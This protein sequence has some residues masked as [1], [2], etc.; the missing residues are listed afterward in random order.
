MKTRLSKIFYQIF[1]VMIGVYL[2]FALNNFGEKRKV[3]SQVK[4]YTNMLLLE[5][6]NNLVELNKVMPYHKQLSTDFSE[7]LKSENVKE[8]F[9]SYSLNGFRPGLVNSSAYETG[10]QTG[11][12][13]QFDLNTIQQI[14]RL[15][16][17][18]NRYNNFNQ[19]MINSFISQKFPETESET[20]SLLRIVSMSLN[21]VSSFE[22]DLSS[23]YTS[24]IKL[25]EKD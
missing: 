7:I 17:L 19:S 21:D 12:I 23:Y 14:N 15:Y 3:K 1:P 24:I 6:G 20:V 2:G 18:Q 5:I 4:T 13:Q 25:L 11:I 9:Q 8:A 22:N 16:T 10:I